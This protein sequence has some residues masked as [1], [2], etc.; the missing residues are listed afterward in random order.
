MRLGLILKQVHFQKLWKKH[1]SAHSY[2]NIKKSDVE[3]PLLQFQFTIF[4][5]E[6]VKKLV[7]TINTASTPSPL[8]EEKLNKAFDVWYPELEKAL[9]QLTDM[10]EESEE[11]AD[12]SGNIK[13]YSHILEE[14]LDL[15]RTNQKLLRNP[16]GALEKDFVAIKEQLSEIQERTRR[17]T[18]VRHNMK[19]RKFHLHPAMLEEMVHMTFSSNS[20]VSVQI[21]LSLFKEDFPWIYDAGVELIQLLKSK[22]TMEKKHKAIE[23]YRELLDFTFRHPIMKDFYRT[24]NEEL[25]MFGKELTHLLIRAVER[26]FVTEF[27]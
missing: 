11:E 12:S 17:N 18:H 4:E 6:D 16:E 20:F 19:S 10:V 21:I 8:S 15:S 5:K 23:E 25:W 1:L 14:I 22:V 7:Q 13:S 24:N 9:N 27:A 26:N 3:G 2:F